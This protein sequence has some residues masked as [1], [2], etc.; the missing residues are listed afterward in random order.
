ME[1][2]LQTDSSSC[3]KLLLL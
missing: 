1:V 2:R 3:D